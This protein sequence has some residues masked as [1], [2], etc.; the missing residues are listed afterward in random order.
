MGDLKK[1]D[2]AKIP[3]VGEVSGD[4]SGHPLCM[5]K[6]SGLRGPVVAQQV[7]NPTS[8]RED[9]GLIPGPC[10]VG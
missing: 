2:E 3:P 9:M 8:I 10:S 1:S 6:R 4:E 7:K 5:N